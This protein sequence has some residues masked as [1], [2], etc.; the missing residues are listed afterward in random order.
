[1]Q[2][3]SIEVKKRICEDFFPNC[4]YCT[5]FSGCF[6]NGESNNG[7]TKTFEIADGINER[8]DKLRNL[9]DIQ[10]FEI[11]ETVKSLLNDQTLQV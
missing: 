2:A 1:M 7:S 3:R 8:M 4:Q 5:C 10:L 11:Y 9:S 6:P